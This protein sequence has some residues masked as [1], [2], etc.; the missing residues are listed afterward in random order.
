MLKADVLLELVAD[1]AL[2]V[3]DD[4]VNFGV[5]V[6]SESLLDDELLLGAGGD[7][8]PNTGPVWVGVP[9]GVPVEVDVPVG[10]EVDFVGAGL[11]VV[12]DD[13]AAGLVTGAITGV[14]GRWVRVLR[15]TSEGT[16]VDKSRVAWSRE[17]PEV[18]VGSIDQ[19]VDGSVDR[20]AAGAGGPTTD[21]AA[22]SPQKLWET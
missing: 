13:G 7:T 18:R 21:G 4:G 14:P 1:G 12:V 5:A 3:L 17:V 2:V 20:G 22:G 10:V 16:W 6:G 15:G 19:G 11:A 8:V 9:L